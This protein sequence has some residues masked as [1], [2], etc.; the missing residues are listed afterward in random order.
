VGGTTDQKANR[1]N[2]VLGLAN[3]ALFRFGEALIDPPVVLTWF[4]SSLTS[5]NFIIGLISPLGMIG[6]FLPQLFVSERVQRM[7]RKMPMYVLGGAIRT[8]AWLL[9]VVTMW[10]AQDPA[11]LLVGFFALYTIARVSSGV[12]GLPFFDIVAK[13]IP[14]RRRGTFFGIRQ[15]V[16]GVLGFGGAWIVARVLSDPALPFPRGHA[17]LFTVYALV[18]GLSVA[19]LAATR[20]P[21]GEART[22]PAT[23]GQQLRRARQ[24]LRDDK[25]FRRHVAARASFG[26]AGIALPFYTVYAKNVLGAPEAMVGV[27]VAV[28]V[29]ASLLFNLPWGRLSDLRGNRLVMRLLSLASGLSALLA[30]ALVVYVGLSRPREAWLPYLALPILFLEG[31]TLPARMLVGNNFLLELVPESERPL[32]LG[33]ASTLVG[34]ILLL[35]LAGGLL[36]DL[37]G[38]A[39]LFAVSLV[40]YLIAY[41]LATALPEPRSDVEAWPLPRAGAGQ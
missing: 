15:L 18:T 7:E 36:A 35:T 6:W 39:G 17:V 16:G 3:G 10:L 22:E 20:E 27:Y 2:Y 23:L 33:V 25:I 1:R 8:A 32:Y 38:F 9:L 37:M 34:T 13:I 30:L 4:V 21:P 11:V 5:S 14:A 12:G 24:L 26:L 40:L 41:R 29:G 28:R 19:A 31:A